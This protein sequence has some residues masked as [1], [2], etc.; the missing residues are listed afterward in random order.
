MPNYVA[1][2]V[3]KSG[4]PAAD[5]M[6]FVKTFLT[7]PKSI[8]TVPGANEA[9][10]AAA[11]RASQDAYAYALT[12]VWYTSIAFGVVSIIA[13]TFLGNNRKYLTNRVAAKIGH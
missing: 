6:E 5:A 10:V 3:L 11:T 4:L 2:A 7:T 12:F 1:A 8:A 9:V 13:A